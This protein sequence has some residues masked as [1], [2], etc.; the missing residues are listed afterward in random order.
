MKR[1]LREMPSKK[2][3]STGVADRVVHIKVE[4]S[5]SSSS[6]MAN[7]KESAW[8]P[9][10]TNDH[11]EAIDIM[12]KIASTRTT[13]TRTTCKEISTTSTVQSK[14]AKFNT[15][16]SVDIIDRHRSFSEPEYR[17]KSTGVNIASQLPTST[18]PL[19]VFKTAVQTQGLKGHEEHLDTQVSLYLTN[20]GGQME[21]QELLPLLVSGPSMFFLTFRL[22]RDLNTP[23]EIV[24][25]I[26]VQ[27]G[28]GSQ[29]KSYKYISSNTP[30][31]TILQ[32]LA[33]ID[34]IG[35]Y[36]DYK[37]KNIALKYRILL[38]GTHRDILEKR[39]SNA[40]S[41]IAK[42]N[43]EIKNAVET[44][45][46]W[47]HIIHADED[48]LIFTVN[49]FAKDDKDFQLIRSSVQKVIEAGDFRDD[50]PSYWLI[51]SLMLQ[52]LGK[53]TE[54]FKK[55][56]EVAKSCGIIE[57]NEL[58]E[59]LYFLDRRMGVIRYF[60]EDKLKNLVILDPQV[61][62][63]KVTQLIVETFTFEHCFLDRSVEEEFKKGI[64][65]LKEFERINKK[66]NPDSTI[67]P[68][69]F[70]DLL[71]HLRIAAPFKEAGIQKYFFPIAISHVAEKQKINIAKTELIICP[72]V[73]SFK[74]GYCPIGL[75]GGLITY[76][77][78]HKV[79]SG[80]WEFRTN[81]IFRD[82][83]TYV[84]CDTNDKVTLKSFPTH[85]EITCIPGPGNR[86]KYPVE[87]TCIEV[88]RL[89]KKG[90]EIA[91]K[92]M[93]YVRNVD[94]TFTFYCTAE[95]CKESRK[96]PAK[97][98]EGTGKIHCIRDNGLVFDLPKGHHYWRVCTLPP[99]PIKRTL[100]IRQLM[101]PS[102]IPA[103]RLL[104]PLASE[105][106]NIG[107]YLHIR[108]GDL[109]TIKTDESRAKSC[110][111]EMLNTWLKQIDPLPTWNDLAEAVQPFNPR[112][113]KEIREQYC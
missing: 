2:S 70:A 47:K 83:V 103:F 76:I 108:C 34:A 63:D 93:N 26:D 80:E 54:S 107:T 60:P 98:I 6:F 24:Y 3:P 75:T 91:T 35:T 46:Y 53:R 71:Q 25:E 87:G 89:F 102:I 79:N 94:I 22:D 55:C 100:P 96:H 45:T 113:A 86:D 41:A 14:I 67:N 16:H 106:Q 64:F 82:Q 88:K 32:S 1:L 95:M 90:I 78:E 57:E 85:L 97:Y 104:D 105:W 40:E 15:E 66:I 99:K 68:K 109:E 51:Y 112:I 30:L 33:S 28:Y 50:Y 21:F 36:T 101:A 38:I 7:I 10:K 65:S 17:G 5:S 58:K 48:H 8:K 19:E 56:F 37:K 31:D 9:I 44:A 52:R 92:R 29:L 43:E 13:S 27:G 81:G 77:M 73:V 61:L 11:D 84:V 74:C 59:A 23:Y 4:K 49:N 62:F 39:T 69:W 12:L 20:T 111:R 42:I 18:S 72:L 110:L